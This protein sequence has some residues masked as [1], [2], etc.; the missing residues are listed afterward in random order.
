MMN[1]QSDGMKTEA[2]GPVREK[3]NDTKTGGEK[4][5]VLPQSGA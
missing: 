3:R 4:L 1:L 5:L 2:M